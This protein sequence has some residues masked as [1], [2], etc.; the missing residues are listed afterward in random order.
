MMGALHDQTRRLFFNS[1]A[2]GGRDAAVTVGRGRVPKPSAISGNAGADAETSLVTHRASPR[3][4]NWRAARGDLVSCAMLKRANAN[5]VG[6]A[7]GAVAM[8][9]GCSSAPMSSGSGATGPSSSS[10]GAA[11]SSS[12]SGGGTGSSSGAGASGSSSGGAATCTE[13]AGVSASGATVWTDG[14]S[15]AASTT[16]AAGTTVVIAP[17]ATINLGAAATIVVSGTLVASSACGSHAQLVW[18]AG[19]SSA[20]GIT[21]AAGGVLR[22]DGVDISG[23]SLPLYVQGTGTAEYDHG[24]LNNVATPFNVSG[25]LTTNGATVTGTRGTSSVSGSFTA[26]GLD[27]NSNGNSGIVATDN[28]TLDIQNSTLHGTG[29]VADMV[30]SGGT[31]GATVNVAHTEIYGVHCAF[32]FDAAKTFTISYTNMHDNAYGFMLFGSGTTGGTMTYSNLDATNSLSFATTPS[33]GPITFD[34]CFIPVPQVT[35]PP[36]VTITNPSSSPVAGVGPM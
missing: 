16:I 25:T 30:I 27:Y 14:M 17:G 5:G 34:H 6:W 23:A 29:P 11:A 3:G 20:S 31:I 10:S 4:Q 24:T 28:A 21:V 7:A 18:P 19:A 35:S 1:R 13:D 9:V 33:N 8:C 2:T 22:L 32:H 15:Q 12:S 26:T 36:V